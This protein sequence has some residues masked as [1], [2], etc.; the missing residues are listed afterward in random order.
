VLQQLIERGALGVYVTFVDEL[1]ALSEATVSMVAGI[2]PGDLS[3]RTY[4]L[5]R[6]P[7]DGRAY[8]LAI[9]E[10]HGLT[11]DAVRRRIAR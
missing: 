4:T 6:R 3:G 5:A 11:Y 1:A 2:A 9:A 8:A 10:R 7:A